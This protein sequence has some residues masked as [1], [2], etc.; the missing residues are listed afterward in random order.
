MDLSK[1]NTVFC[2]EKL[3][4]NW[5]YKNGLPRNAIIKTS[6]PTLILDKKDKYN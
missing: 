6:S 2:D 4:L 1:L 5:A 3:D